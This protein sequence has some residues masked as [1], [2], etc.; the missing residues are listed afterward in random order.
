MLIKSRAIDRLIR[1]NPN[2]RERRFGLP[3]IGT[4]TDGEKFNPT[5]QSIADAI[6]YYGYKIRDED[7]VNIPGTDLGGGNPIGFKPFPLSIKEMK[8]SLDSNNLHKYTYTEGDDR[9]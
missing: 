6:D 7:I 8:K 1:E 9:T 5:V 2:L 4:R 3:D